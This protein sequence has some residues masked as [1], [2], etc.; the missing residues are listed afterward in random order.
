MS[1]ADTLPQK[2]SQLHANDESPRCEIPPHLAEELAEI[3]ADA[4]V[5][6]Y[7]AEHSRTERQLTVSAN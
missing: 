7:Y 4:L 5:A 1:P 6:D 2:P 3:I